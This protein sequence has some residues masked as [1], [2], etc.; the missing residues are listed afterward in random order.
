MIKKVELE[1]PVFPKKV[2]IGS[3]SDQKLISKCFDDLLNYLNFSMSKY[4]NVIS[5]W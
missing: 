4:D 2:R 1:L 5:T 3:F